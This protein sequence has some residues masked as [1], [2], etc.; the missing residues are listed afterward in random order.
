M[1][2]R[3]AATEVIAKL[4]NISIMDSDEKALYKKV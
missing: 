1:V 2:M 3:K 4:K